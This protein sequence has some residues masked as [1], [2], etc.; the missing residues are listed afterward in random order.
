MKA[1]WR[2]T[3]KRRIINAVITKKFNEWTATLEDE[4]VRKLVEKN[5]IITGGCIEPP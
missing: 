4:A 3:M 2:K 5:T 1:A